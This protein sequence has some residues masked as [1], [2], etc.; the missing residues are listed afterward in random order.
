MLEYLRQFHKYKIKV[1]QC[2]DCTISSQTCTYP[3]NRCNQGI[4]KGSFTKY[5]L[6]IIHILQYYRFDIR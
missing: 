1:K 3:Q 5:C 6:L 2:S 4:Y